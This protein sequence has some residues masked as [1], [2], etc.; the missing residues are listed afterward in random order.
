MKY[1]HSTLLTALLLLLAL[2]LPS[3]VA[4]E[5]AG[6]QAEGYKVTGLVTDQ[7]D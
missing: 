1:L 4:E 3:A 6:E 7:T 5:I 2:P